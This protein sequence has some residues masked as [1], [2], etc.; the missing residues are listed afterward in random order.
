MDTFAALISFIVNNLFVDVTIKGL[1]VLNV[2]TSDYVASLV[3][4]Y[5]T[6]TRISLVEVTALVE[7]EVE[8]RLYRNQ[9]AG[10]GWGFEYRYMTEAQY[11]MRLKNEMGAP[12]QGGHHHYGEVEEGEQ[13]IGMDLI[14]HRKV[15]KEEAKRLCVDYVVS[16]RVSTE[17][18][19]KQ[20]EAAQRALRS[21]EW[22]DVCEEDIDY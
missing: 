2:S 7:T 4:G 20:Y 1:K 22:A 16:E 15:V 17:E 13:P 21:W 18:E 5:V 19:I 9:P 10:Y 14:T 12:Y 11:S 3:D 6:E 8:T